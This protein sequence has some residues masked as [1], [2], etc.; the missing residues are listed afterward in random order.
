MNEPMTNP[1]TIERASIP[2]LPTDAPQCWRD[3]HSILEADT[4]RVVLYGPPG[5]GKTF[6]GL[7]IGTHVEAIRLICTED[8]TD[9]EIV[10]RFLP[11]P[12][13]GMTWH[14]GAVIRAWRTGARVVIDEID[15]ANGDILSTLLAMTDTV[16]SSRW[17]HPTTGEIVT[18]HPEFSVVMTTN[19]ERMIDLPDALRDRFPVQI[20]ID[21]PHPLALERLPEVWREIARTSADLDIETRASIRAFLEVA[22]LEVAIGRADAI[23]LVFGGNPHNAKRIAQAVEIATLALENPSDEAE[24]ISLEQMTSALEGAK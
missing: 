11:N 10:G 2:T 17:E 3:V 1:T 23:R 9:G 15:K 14:E 12:N 24:T 13:G 18:P 22:R 20:R 7:N 5:T 16:D 8:M 6:A 19:L 21:E 4:R